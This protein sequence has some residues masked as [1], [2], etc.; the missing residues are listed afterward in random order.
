M[1][2]Y[3]FIWIIIV[4]SIFIIFGVCMEKLLFY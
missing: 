4:L 1:C 2:A 3:N